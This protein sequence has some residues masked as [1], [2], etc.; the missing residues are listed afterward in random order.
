MEKQTL[1]NQIISKTSNWL[2]N[3]N[4]E[5]FAKGVKKGATATLSAG[6]IASMLMT[7]GCD[8]TKTPANTDVSNVETTTNAEASG[9]F[10]SELGK[11]FMQ[12]QEY[13]DAQEE[14]GD[15]VG[16]KHLAKSNVSL[17]PAGYFRAMGISEDDINYNTGIRADLITEDSLYLFTYITNNLLKEAP[18]YALYELIQYQNLPQDIINDLVKHKSEKDILNYSYLVRKISENYTPVV[19]TKSYIA[20]TN[21][22]KNV[23]GTGENVVVKSAGIVVDENGKKVIYALG[24]NNDGL[25][26]LAKSVTDW[27]DFEKNILKELNEGMHHI[28]QTVTKFVT[29]TNYEILDTGLASTTL[30]IFPSTYQE[31]ENSLENNS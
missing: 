10:S 23:E 8:N 18:D 26:V 1:I 13:K 25:P 6:L 16:Y 9:E 24:T 21:S 12:T 15:A 5:K 30:F 14:Y 17:T 3:F 29:Q 7:A 11:Q 31:P 4:Y 19:I 2:K 27:E 22:S 20:P 28:A